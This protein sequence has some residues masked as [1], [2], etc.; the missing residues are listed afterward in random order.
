[1]T[2]YDLVL[3][4]GEVIDPAQNVHGRRDIAFADGKV[5]AIEEHI[6]PERAARLLDVS[7]SHVVPGLVDIHSHFFYGFTP[8]SRDPRT[9]IVP[10]GVTCSVDAGTAGSENFTNLRE[11]VMKPS[12]LRLYAFLNAEVLGMAARRYTDERMPFAHPD[13]AAG[14]VKRN[15]ETIVGVK[16]QL[17]G[18]QSPYVDDS[19]ALLDCGRRAARDA[20]V[21]MMVHI[22]GGIEIDEL[23]GR[24]EPGDII[25]HCFQGREP[26]VLTESGLH[27]A[28]RRAVERGVLLDLAPA[29]RNHFAWRVAAAVCKEGYFPNTISSDYATA[30]RG[31]HGF[32]R[33]LPEAMSMMLSLGMPLDD[34][35]AAATTTPASALGLGD[36]HGTLQVGRAG[37]AAVLRLDQVS[38]EFPDMEGGSRVLDEVLTPRVTVLGGEIV[39][40]SSDE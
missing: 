30:P 5:A 15:R 2:D 24:L 29:G 39:W 18:S 9:D 22:D 25:T 6:A 36:R 35:V 34:V 20:G 27:P 10:T 14:M 21:P 28:V 8:I 23:V 12:A 17:P 13:K 38:D 40:E 19:I 16:V 11:F 1:M 33:S 31:V 7:G 32:M 4:G 26:S 3:A 37:D